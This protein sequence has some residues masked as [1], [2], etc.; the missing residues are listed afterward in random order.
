MV[1]DYMRLKTQNEEDIAASKRGWDAIGTY[2]H[3]KY[4]A[5]KNLVKRT[6]FK[7]TILR[8]GGLTNEPG[9]GKASIGRTH[10]SPT[11]SVRFSPTSR[12]PKTDLTLNR[13]MT[14]L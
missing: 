9:T 10:L 1:P 7:W 11:I 13:E 8:P 12:S 4:E 2:M 14:S 6:A 5:D 3:W